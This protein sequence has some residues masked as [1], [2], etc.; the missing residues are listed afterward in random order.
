[1]EEH[2]LGS[3]PELAYNPLLPLQLCAAGVAMVVRGS[4]GRK[5]GSLMVAP[6]APW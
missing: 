1:M 6:V 4:G 2:K 5:G 3:Q